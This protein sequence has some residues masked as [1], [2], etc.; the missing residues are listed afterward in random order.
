M[1]VVN[2]WGHAQQQPIRS[3]FK[4][5]TSGDVKTHQQ[6]EIQKDYNAISEAVAGHKRTIHADIYNVA[7]TQIAGLQELVQETT[8]NLIYNDVRINMDHFFLANT[9][10]VVSGSVAF[11][12]NIE[13][14][15]RMTA[16]STNG[17]SFVIPSGQKILVPGANTQRIGYNLSVATYLHKNVD[18][19]IEYVFD[20]IMQK[21]KGVKRTSGG[22]FYY[23]LDHQTLASYY[24]FCTIQNPLGT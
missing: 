4:I 12:D 2:Y 17:A 10:K 8:G 23:Y 9:S 22:R 21:V 15:P 13:V 19:G 5:T 14:G 16:Q 6:R 11:K 7:P 20:P 3:Q 18:N 24:H 1:E